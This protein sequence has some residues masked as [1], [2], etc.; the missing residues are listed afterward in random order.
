MEQQFTA[1]ERERLHIEK[2][3]ILKAQME[4]RQL[5]DPVVRV[6]F[7]NLEDPTAEGRPS[8]PVSFVY[9]R[10]Q[11]R[12]SRRPEDGPDT[13]LRDGNTYNLPMS[14]VNHLNN[15]KVPIYGQIIDPVTKA[16][17]TFVSGHKSR[18]ACIPVDITNFTEI[19]GA[20]PDAQERRTPGRQAIAA[21][22]VKKEIKAEAKKKAQETEQT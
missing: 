15:L 17:K 12:E 9:G 14:V 11:F 5:V 1:Q 8:P 7:Q 10:Y 22:A 21:A 19:Q 13:A 6:R 4:E 20:K 16:L 2:T 3:R 18:F